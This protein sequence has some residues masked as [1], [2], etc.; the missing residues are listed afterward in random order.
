MSKLSKALTFV[1][2]I[3]SLSLFVFP[4]MAQIT[5]IS[6]SDCSQLGISCTG[7]EDSSTLVQKITTIANAFLVLVG[8]VASIY[9]VFGGVRYIM[10][11][12]DE[13]QAEKAKLTIL[14]AV[15]G[16]VI[17][18]LSAAIVNFSVYIASG[19]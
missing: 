5:K 15:I 9:L 3:T 1:I 7:S 4:V 2:A 10:S 6:G 18:G 19:Q 17:I 13:S 8:V 12:G 11:Q 16:I 14:Y